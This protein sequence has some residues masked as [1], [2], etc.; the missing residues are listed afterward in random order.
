MSLF[1]RCTY[2]VRILVLLRGIRDIAAPPGPAHDHHPKQDADDPQDQRRHKPPNGN[3][4]PKMQRQQNQG[5]NA[6]L[7][8]QHHVDKKAEEKASAAACSSH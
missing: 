7:Q 3:I 2:G 5:R 1:L 4:Q 8:I 6:P